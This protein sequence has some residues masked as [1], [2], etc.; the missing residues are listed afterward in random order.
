MGASALTRDPQLLGPFPGHPVQI[1][2]AVCTPRPFTISH[3]RRCNFTPRYQRIPPQRL[4][5]SA[6]A[7]HVV[8]PGIQTFQ[9]SVSNDAGGK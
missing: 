4:T 2:K 9:L 8:K 1:A 6:E 3:D 5:V 7:S